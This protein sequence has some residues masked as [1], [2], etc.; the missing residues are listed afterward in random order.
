MNTLLK[1]K[2]TQAR[3]ISVRFARGMLYVAL[4]DGREIGL[5]LSKTKW[6]QWLAQATPKQRHKWSIDRWGEAVYWEDLDD[7]IEVCHL[8]TPLSLA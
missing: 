3:A 1:N 6:L 2:R 5:S 7:G 8:L 4:N